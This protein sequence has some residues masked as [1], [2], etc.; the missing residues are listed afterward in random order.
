MYCDWGGGGGKAKHCNDHK[1]NSNAESNSRSIDM[2]C[3][4][5]ASACTTS[6]AGVINRPI[7][8]PVE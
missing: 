2:I 8:A 5:A 4:F 3:K 6:V 7:C 1:V